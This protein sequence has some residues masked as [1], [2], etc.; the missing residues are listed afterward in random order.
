MLKK[1]TLKMGKRKKK[2]TG[3]TEALQEAAKIREVVSMGKFT[4]SGFAPFSR[5]EK[6]KVFFPIGFLYACLCPVSSVCS[7]QSALSPLLGFP[8]SRRVI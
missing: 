5:D 1:Y 6:E 3:G 4:L 7:T 2:D 8:N